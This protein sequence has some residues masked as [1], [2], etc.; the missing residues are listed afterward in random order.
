M[1]KSAVRVSVERI[2]GVT[3]SWFE[4]KLTEQTFTNVL[5]VEVD[6]DTDPQSEGHRPF[7]L[8]AIAEAARDFLS[9]ETTRAVN[10][11]IVVP[12]PF[13]GSSLFDGAG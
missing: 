4:W 6:W 3:R 12:R 11:L 8:D 2:E 10:S 7:R 1:G 9:R 13:A 5:V